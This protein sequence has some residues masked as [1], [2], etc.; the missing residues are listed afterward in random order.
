MPASATGYTE[1]EEMSNK[2]LDPD[3]RRRIILE[4]LKPDA[5]I[6]ALA[7]KHGL[8]RGTIYGHLNRVMRDPKGQW[9]EA[10]AEAAFR[11]KVWEL[12]R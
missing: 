1:E 4:A 3:E 11:R 5:D 7:R 12:V 9:R 8:Q 2:R 6:S 10:E